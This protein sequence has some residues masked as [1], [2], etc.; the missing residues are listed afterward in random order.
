[1]QAWNTLKTTILLAALTGLLIVVG[2]ALGGTSGMVIAFVLAVAMNHGRVVVQRQA[3]TEHERRKT[4]ERKRSA[5][6]TSDGRDVERA[7]GYSETG[8]VFD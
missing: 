5:G 1:M 2:S 3:G 6:T 8:G 4:S 7:R